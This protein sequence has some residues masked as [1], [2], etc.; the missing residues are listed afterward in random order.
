M[1]A[2]RK[3]SGLALCRRL[4]TETRPFAWHIAGLF[5]LSLLSA[6]LMLLNPIPLKLVVDSVL[7]DHDLP[8]A[9]AWLLPDGST[10]SSVASI[11]I[12]AGLAV[13]IALLKQLSDL[14][15]AL[16]RT[17][18]GE[19]LVLAF[20]AKLFRHVQRLSLSYHDTQ[21]AA[22]STYRIQY[23]APAIQWITI[24]A[25]I[26]LV[27]AVFTLVAM[28]V[29]MAGLDWQLALVALAVAPALFWV[30]Q[31]FA[32]RLKL[33]WREA[34]DIESS[35]L[36]V[37]QE[38]LSS[39]RVVKAFAA[40][41]REQARYVEQAGQ[42]LREQLRLAF[43]GGSLSLII[44]MIMAVGMAAVLFLGAQHVQSGKL[45]L[46]NFILVM[47]Y[48]ALL[49]GPLQTLSKSA[50]SL[51][52][53]IVSMERAFE[54]LDNAPEVVEKTNA[55]PLLRSRGE[56]SYRDVCF[57]Y[58]PERP[59]LRDIS[60]DVPAGARVGIAGTTGAG[61]STLVS[62]LL[63]LY[64]PERGQI[65]L[66]GVDVRE[67]KLRDL[68]NQFAIVLQEPVLFSC[69]IG[70]NIAYAKP[71]ATEAEIIAAAKAA[72][73]H[74]FIERLKRGYKTEVGERGV[75]LSGGERQRISLARAFLKDASILILDEPTSSVDVKTEALIMEAMQ[76]L[77]QGRTTF[78][79]AH[80][81]TTL[82]VCDMR[83]QLE[84]GRVVSVTKSDVKLAN[85]R[86]SQ[87]K[88]G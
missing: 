18:T 75:Q 46:G 26:P 43:T 53:S 57:A 7:G 85:A 11:A 88:A 34:K 19:K 67:F 42:G 37:V 2:P 1:S 6:P 36:G 61:K 17:F 16:S 70:E 22:D 15:F 77:M 66:D 33:R 41:D 23:D 3:L 47:S 20:R 29:V 74:D 10:R 32:R 86:Q 71:E 24:D 81:L 49:Y 59:A 25:V 35:T 56:V 51:Q 44:G 84:Q 52:G 30:S 27:T 45:T 38:V 60:F 62:L 14:G 48:L 9:L 50:A 39:V 21:G 58:N 31:H 79:I 4:M 65:L 68:R 55:R 78:M 12:I 76:R 83:I 8:A 13:F 64:D 69:S 63:R 87:P 28:V 73:A 82:E 80:R 72:N 5:A 54:L 40:E